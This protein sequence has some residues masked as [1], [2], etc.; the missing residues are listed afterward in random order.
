MSS[1]KALRI[2]RIPY[3]T[4]CVLP[5]FITLLIPPYTTPYI[6]SA[7][8]LYFPV[9]SSWKALRIYRIPYAQPAQS[10]PYTV[11]K[12]TTVAPG[13]HVFGDHI[14]TATLNGAIASGKRA[15]Q[16]ILSQRA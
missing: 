12:P 16:D 1:W 4:P 6:P 3:I 8:P 2:Y 9:V 13:I 11:N 7:F 15:A 10:P 5:S 14:G